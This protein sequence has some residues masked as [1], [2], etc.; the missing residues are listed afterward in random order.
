MQASG[1]FSCLVLMYLMYFSTGSTVLVL[2]Q[3]ALLNSQQADRV[4]AL[5]DPCR[6][7]G[8]SK[9]S[10]IIPIKDRVNLYRN[11]IMNAISCATYSFNASCPIFANYPSVLASPFSRVKKRMFFLNS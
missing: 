2:R 11:K 7:S 1:N 6:Q 9:P 10:I 4:I 3:P 5:A 8:H